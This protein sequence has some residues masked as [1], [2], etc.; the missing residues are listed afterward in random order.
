MGKIIRKKAGKRIRKST[1][2]T[3]IYCVLPTKFNPPESLTFLGGGVY[4][5]IVH[6]IVGVIICIE[7]IKEEK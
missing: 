2:Y 1:I 4:N 5:E 3:L 6:Y 7:N